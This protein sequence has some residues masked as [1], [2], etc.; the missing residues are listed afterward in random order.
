MANLIAPGKAFLES[1]MQDTCSLVR[2]AEGIND[3][4]LDPVTFE[5]LHPYEDDFILYEGPC[6]ITPESRRMQE[7]VQ[8]GFDPR[9]EQI[10][11]VYVPLEVTGIIEGDVFTL[12]EVGED[13]DTNLLNVGMRVQKVFGGTFRAGRK[14]HV[15][16]VAPDRGNNRG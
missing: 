5:L 7:Y 10:Y 6:I 1:L 4:V 14:L 3:D 8:A 15:Q 16:Y 11:R 9:S 12:T 2:D 13:N